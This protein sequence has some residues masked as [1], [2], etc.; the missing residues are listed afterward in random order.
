MKSCSSSGT[1]KIL[2]G[3]RTISRGLLCVCLGK[4]DPKFNQLDP[5]RTRFIQ[6]RSLWLYLGSAA[7]LLLTIQE[8]SAFY[9][10][11]CT[12]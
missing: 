8:E 6:S 11:C 2:A 10:A 12:E 3:S 7:L 4:I 1:G 9:Q 5:V